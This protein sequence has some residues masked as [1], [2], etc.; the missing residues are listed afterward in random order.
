MREGRCRVFILVDIAG[1]IH[2]DV[3][4]A[5][6]V[7]GDRIIYYDARALNA[8]GESRRG[9][10]FRLPVELMSVVNRFFT[11]HGEPAL[12]RATAHMLELDE[13][14]A[15]VPADAIAAFKIVKGPIASGEAVIKHRD[16]EVRHWIHAFNEKT[17]AVETEAAGLATAAHEEGRDSRSYGALVIRGISDHADHDKNDFYRKT[18]AANAVETLRLLLP[19]IASTLLSERPTSVRRSRASKADAE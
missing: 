12:A 9:D 7:I 17:L 15:A 19:V 13:L 5:D 11:L 14:G 8:H 2:K 18:A 16:S 4:L 6:V 1:G 10:E 3:A